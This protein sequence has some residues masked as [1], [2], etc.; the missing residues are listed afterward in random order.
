ML[1]YSSGSLDISFKK[2]PKAIIT[3]THGN[4]AEAKLIFESKTVELVRPICAE[5]YVDKLLNRD[6]F[7]A[8]CDKY[9]TRYD[10]LKA[11]GGITPSDT[12]PT[13]FLD[14]IKWR[15][16]IAILL[17]GLITSL[18][19]DIIWKKRLRSGNRIRASIEILLICA[20]IF[21]LIYLAQISYQQA[22]YNKYNT[23]ALE[24]IRNAA[25][26]EEGYYVDNSK[27]CDSIEELIGETY[28]LKLPEGVSVH[29]IS[30][31]ETKYYLLSFHEKG[32]KGY[33]LKGGSSISDKEI[34]KAEAVSI[35][36]PYR[37]IAE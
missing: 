29:V 11:L 1:G 12:G 23:E 34:S 3:D 9:K 8:L 20:A 16:L 33:L 15:I 26:A 37:D 32:S 31:S 10:I 25:T 35:I 24:C 13:R 36:K 19:I 22:Q 6:E 14:S 4:P 7:R 28:G 21:I 2:E 18:V 27:Y 17:F 30:A 5:I